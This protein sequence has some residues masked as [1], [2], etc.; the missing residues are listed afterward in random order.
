MRWRV[1]VR[2][3]RPRTDTKGRGGAQATLVFVL[4]P[5]GAGDAG[6]HYDRSAAQRGGR[7]IRPR[8]RAHQEIANQLVGQFAENLKAR[9]A[10]RPPTRRQPRLVGTCTRGGAVGRAAAPISGIRLLLAALR[11]MLARWVRS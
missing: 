8:R 11:A 9:S 4:V 10:S 6:R 1:R 2:V 5:D 7:A 3:A